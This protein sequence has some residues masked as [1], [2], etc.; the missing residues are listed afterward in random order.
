MKSLKMVVIALAAFVVVGIAGCTKPPLKVPDVSILRV[1][2]QRVSTLNR[3]VLEHYCQWFIYATDGSLTHNLQV[4]KSH[5]SGNAMIPKSLLGWRVPVTRDTNRCTITDSSAKCK[6]IVKIF[7]MEFVF[8][9][10][11]NPVNLGP[12]SYRGNITMTNSKIRSNIALIEDIFKQV[13]PKMSISVKATTEWLNRMNRLAKE[14][15]P[16]QPS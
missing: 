4:C 12:K 13:H 3:V 10:G 7:F 1:D 5:F 9:V 6:K 8:V 16:K 14:N 15:P 11:E 2:V